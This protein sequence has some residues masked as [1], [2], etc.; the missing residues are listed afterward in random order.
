MASSEWDGATR[1]ELE[2]HGAAA[3]ETGAPWKLHRVGESCRE[4]EQSA[5]QNGKKKK[6]ITRSQ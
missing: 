4:P 6:K 5:E 1:A 2:L 3:L